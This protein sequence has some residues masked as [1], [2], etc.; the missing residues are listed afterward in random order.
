[1]T[2][3]WLVL[4]GKKIDNTWIGGAARFCW[5]GHKISIDVLYSSISTYILLW[6]RSILVVGAGMQCSA[7]KFYDFGGTGGCYNDE[8]G[9]LGGEMSVQEKMYTEHWIMNQWEWGAYHVQHFLHCSVRKKCWT[10]SAEHSTSK[11]PKFSTCAEHSTSE[12]QKKC[13]TLAM[14]VWI[15][16]LCMGASALCARAL[17]AHCKITVR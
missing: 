14:F 10:E 1:M 12:N 2:K 16:S 4:V 15:G 13:W 11:N 3:D 9:K 5:I 8:N 7:L 6:K 17:C